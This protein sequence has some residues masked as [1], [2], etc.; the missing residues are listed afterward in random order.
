[1]PPKDAKAAAPTNP[2][3]RSNN[4]LQQP[5]LQ[6][7]MDDAIATSSSESLESTPPAQTLILTQQ[8]IQTL[9]ELQN[10]IE[11]LTIK[12]DKLDDLKDSIEQLPTRF[13]TNLDSMLDRKRRI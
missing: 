9:T 8:L 5:A 3:T 1:M 10:S 11:T 7:Q 4:S 6:D 12:I 13:D 2:K